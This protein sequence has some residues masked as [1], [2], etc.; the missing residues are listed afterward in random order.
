M[1]GVRT[2]YG[3]DRVPVLALKAGVDQLLNPP[4]LDVAWNAVLKAVRDGELTEA[5]LDESIL[6]ILR[7][8]AKLGL[9]EDPYVTREGVDRVVG[10]RPHLAAADRIAERTTTLLVTRA[11]CCRCPGAAGRGCSS[12]APT[13]PPRPARPDR[14]PGCSRAH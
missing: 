9:F 6:R 10:A 2:K 12:S 8:K 14:R 11:A 1:E 4:S 3:D 5:R 13:R 7:L